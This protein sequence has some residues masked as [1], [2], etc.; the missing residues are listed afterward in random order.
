[1]HVL[2]TG[3]AGF[4]GSHLCDLLL[5]QGYRVTALDDLSLGRIEFL[6]RALTSE[7]FR[8]HR[9]DILERDRLKSLFA[10]G[11][12]D[13]VFH[14]VANSDIQQG[15]L[16]PERDLNLTF[17]SSFRVLEA[18]CLHGPKKVL[19]ASSS[20]VYGETDD[21]ISDE[22]G[23]F[24]PISFYGAAKLAAEAYL[25]AHAHNHKVQAWIFRFP[26]VVG[27]RATHG[28]LYDFIR[29]L[30]ANPAKL[31]ILGDGKQSKPY[32]YVLDLIK[33]MMAAWTKMTGA[34]NYLNI[35]PDDNLSVNRVADIVCEEMCLTDVQ[36]SYSGGNRGWK[37]DVA[38]YIYDT[39]RMKKL[40]FQ[41]TKSSE[42]SV[43]QAVRRMLG[44]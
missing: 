32:V 1:M 29:K 25:S 5:E 26:N 15:V 20:A 10:Q 30:S 23:P 36:F 28:I 43:R 40:G 22:H 11:R 31:E 18:M 3:G 37:G 24:K 7:D 14:L 4:I 13:A 16:D 27:E 9:M 8:F 17:L 41:I 12:F 42:E 35:G 21:S 2:V 38:R 19:F 44:K 34:L 6:E 39:T 33:I